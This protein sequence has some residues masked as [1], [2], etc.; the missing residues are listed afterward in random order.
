MHLCYILINGKI[1]I[2]IFDGW[3]EFKDSINQ[4]NLR[5]Y[6][7]FTT[8]SYSRLWVKDNFYSLLFIY[9][10]QAITFCQLL[11]LYLHIVKVWNWSI[12]KFIVWFR[13]WHQGCWLTAFVVKGN[14]RWLSCVWTLDNSFQVYIFLFRLSNRYFVMRYSYRAFSSD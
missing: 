6:P 7:N 12:N 9:T 2:C 1:N 13:S 8:C 14:I 3:P 10:H 4:L 11:T 5:K